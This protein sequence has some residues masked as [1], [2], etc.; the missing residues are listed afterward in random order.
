[1]DFLVFVTERSQHKQAK[2]F[3][4]SPFS[5]LIVAFF[6][7]HE[8]AIMLSNRLQDTALRYFLEVVRSGSVSEAA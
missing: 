2:L 7:N 8:Q 5:W 3:R 6:A 4:Q 1:M